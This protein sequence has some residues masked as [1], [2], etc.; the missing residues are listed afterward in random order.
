[1]PKFNARSAD[2]NLLFGILALQMDF[3]DRDSLVAAMHAWVLAKDKPLGR[4]LIEQG[5]LK[6]ELLALIDALVQAHLEVHEE[7]PER[8]LAAV[9]A[10]DA[11]RRDLAR[12]DDAELQASV[13][14]VGSGTSVDP[15]ATRSEVVGRSVG[16]AALRYH[17]LRPHAKGGI[18]EVFLAEDEQLH[19]EVALKEIQERYAGDETCR[20]RFLLEAE[21]TGGLE[22]P[23]IVPIYG[24]GQYADGRPFYAMRFIRGDN[25]KQAIRR[26]HELD[27]G[28]PSRG[29][30]AVRSGTHRNSERNIAFRQLLRRF[31]DVCNAVAYAHSRGILHRDVKPG[32]IMLGNYGE[33]LLVD[34][35][36][37]KAAG[38]PE[39]ERHADIPVLRPSSGSGAGLTVSGSVLG[40]PAYMSP[41]QSRGHLEEL[42]PASDVYSLGATLYTLLTGHAP[43]AEDDEV[44]VLARVQR[45]DFPRPRAI[46]AAVPL[47]LEAVCLKA[48]AL[49]PP[50]R[51]VSARALADD[52]EH[53][54]ADEPV[55]A[56]P[57]PIWTRLRRW[58][59]R[60]QAW[61]AG[62]AALLVTAVA[63]LG[64]GLVAVQREERRTEAARAEEA[65]RRQQARESLDAMSS[66]VIDDWLVKQRELLPEHRAFLQKALASYEEFAQE[67][68]DDESTRASVAAAARRVGL[69]SFKLG[70]VSDANAA[71]RR[72]QALYG[73]LTADFPDRPDYRQELARVHNN[74]G[75]M[76]RTA[77]QQKEAEADFRDAILLQT[78]LAA[79]FPA[80]QD[81]RQEL[82]QSD[83]NLGILLASAGRNK[84]ADLAYQEAL[85]L[86]KQLVAEAPDQPTYRRQ[87]AGSYGN[88]GILRTNMG[89][90]KEAEA[91]YRQ[92]VVLEQQLVAEFPTLPDYRQQLARHHNNLGV[93]LK[94]AG[95][96]KEA[97]SAYR[98]AVVLEKQLAADFPVVPDY[99]FELSNT[100]SNLGELANSQRKY[101]EACRWLDEALP[102]HQA[103]LR[104]NPRQ[105]FYRES[106]RNN[107]IALA[108]ARVAMGDHAGVAQAA[109]EMLELGY[110][111]VDDHY[112]VAR[113]LARCIP[114]AEADTNLPDARRKEVAQAYA[115]RALTS[116]DE[117]ITKGYRDVATM[118]TDKHL[119]SL[120]GYEEF[121]R[122]LAA[123]EAQGKREEK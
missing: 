113:F 7:D 95:R 2:R 42:G 26:F 89:R 10:V 71:Y 92:A 110:D 116:L 19:R 54:L 38:R 44:P 121:K 74:M 112:T 84:D 65:R 39:P 62:A 117:A 79:E 29:A 1:M 91:F 49:R 97:E 37:A 77:G 81:Y 18:G 82:A 72:A 22:H 55:T 111:P 64:L 67:T 108:E 5:K 53:W 102:H 46:Q 14:M 90:Y 47:A 122:L 60:H 69:I 45:G 41:E 27:R 20:S 3:I 109:K 51:Y 98:D 76:H 114:A 6:A 8:S 94:D 40:T 23:G 96:P 115:R 48:M 15:E 13:S 118:R 24:L 75:D 30:G 80:R 9:A 101:A 28:F 16:S 66:Q 106:F 57:E 105:R 34:W 59:R 73:L 107:R 36:L 99:Q 31:I 70:Q 61:V 86:R 43:F 68:Q 93:L 103:A 83:N 11:V 85:A 87:L 4:I 100:L 12:I 21:I 32:N 63:A 120:R 78:Q 25:L 50:D 88:L 56:Y 119:E 17:I 35:G 123:L 58:S 104:G 33:T 52:I